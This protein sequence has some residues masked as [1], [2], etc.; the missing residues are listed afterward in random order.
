MLELVHILKSAVLISIFVFGMML[1]TDYL[2]V[3]SKGRMAALIRGG[4][5]RQYTTASFLGAT[6]GCL[7]A[8]MNVSFYVHR[9]IGFGAIVGGMIATSGDEA[10]VMLAVFPKTAL[11]LFLLLFVLGTLLAWLTDRLAPVFRV[12]PC[13]GCEED[14]VHQS[15]IEGQL[16]SPHAW[17]RIFCAS[18]F[19]LVL[20]LSV[21]VLLLSVIF[22]VLGPSSWD[23]ERVALLTILVV[24]GAA[25]VTAP[26]HYIKEHIWR[27]IVRAHLWRVFLWTLFALLMVHLLFH[28]W[29]LESFVKAHMVWVLILSAL[30]GVVPE[31]GPHLVFVMMFSQG[32][33]PFSVLLT[34]SIVQDGHGMLPLL[35]YSVRDSVRVKSFNLVYGLLIGGGLYLLGM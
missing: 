6:P 15:H 14:L 16:V 3:L 24:I 34:S 9:L 21:T 27:H 26:D 2:N 22:G 32:L 33:V 8:F 10:F 11:V 18:G 17:R 12:K 35:S 31:S 23:F 1:V 5:W 7:G 4:R 29:D 28:Y 25:T 19:R 13:E 30:V 20:F